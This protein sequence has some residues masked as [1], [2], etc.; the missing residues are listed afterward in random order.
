MPS[1]QV[2]MVFQTDAKAVDVTSKAI[3]CHRTA[4]YL[5][6]IRV[7]ARQL[8]PIQSALILFDERP[9]ACYYPVTL[10]GFWYLTKEH[11]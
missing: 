3:D 11:L 8:V 2:A 4:L 7:T 5:E 9:K 1:A 6:V 10:F